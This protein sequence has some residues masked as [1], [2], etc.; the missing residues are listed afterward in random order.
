MTGKRS[1]TDFSLCFK[2]SFSNT[3]HSSKSAWKTHMKLGLLSD[4]LA[5]VFEHGR[6][7]TSIAVVSFLWIIL[8]NDIQ[9]LT[10][11]TNK[12]IQVQRSFKYLASWSP[13]HSCFAFP[14]S[15]P[16]PISH[17]LYGRQTGMPQT[18]HNKIKQVDMIKW[19]SQFSFAIRRE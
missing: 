17:C 16:N 10:I 3:F 2:W 1:N 19:N 4:T 9:P 6:K 8:R 18:P 7:D 13:S 5:M 15:Q 12:Y 11:D 14:L